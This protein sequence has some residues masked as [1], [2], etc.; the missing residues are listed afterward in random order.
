MGLHFANPLGLAAGFD[1][2]ASHIDAL[3]GLGFGF[4]EVGAVT[5]RPQ[6]GNAKPRVFRLPTQRALINRMGFNNAGAAAAAVALR[7]RQYAG[8]VGVN[9]GKNAQT[10]EANAA[11]DYC[12]ALETLYDFGDFFTINVSSP[13]TPGLQ[14]LQ[15][16]ERLKALLAAVVAKRDSL[17]ARRG[18]RA[19]IAVKLSPDLSDRELQEA[20][21]TVAN[22]GGDG[23]VACNT[24]Q[25][26]PPAV[27]AS[28]HGKEAGGLSGLPL[29]E[30][31]LRAVEVLRA[32]LPAGF[33]I[34]GVGGIFGADD[35]KRR[36][37]AGADLLQI[38]TGLV[39]EG[40]G[41][42]RRIISAL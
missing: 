35:A 17:A 24:T 41:L 23:V 15:H 33:A 28:Q 14:N 2:N 32:A 37:A 30:R 40:P 16:G 18:K 25:E 12:E 21:A 4:V 6:A 13:N 31:A 1:K 29:A 26:R 9:L 10:A 8:V 11:A 27:A 22:G 34:V 19:P 3:G 5:P 36:L 20:A 38:Y 42:P 39:Y 7:R